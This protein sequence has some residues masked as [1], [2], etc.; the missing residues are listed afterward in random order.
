MSEKIKIVLALD[1]EQ[2]FSQGMTNAQKS[3]GI[4][5]S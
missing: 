1:G 3:P 4:K 2:E 5:A